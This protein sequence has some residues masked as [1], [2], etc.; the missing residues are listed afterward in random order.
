[1][2][3]KNNSN[4]INIGDEVQ[5]YQYSN[6]IP[7]I[8]RIHEIKR[9]DI[10]LIKLYNGEFKQVHKPLINKIKESNNTNIL[11]KIKTFG[12]YF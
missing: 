12:H 9:N 7:L 10:Y 5:C 3:L 6:H 1:M 2:M 8:G 11:E 4:K